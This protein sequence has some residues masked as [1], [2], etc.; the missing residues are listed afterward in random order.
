M[1][2]TYGLVERAIRHCQIL[3]TVLVETMISIVTEKLDTQKLLESVSSPKSGASVLFVGTTR[4]FTG[5]RETTFLS[6][7]CYREMAIVKLQELCDRAQEKWPIEKCG[8]V[9]RI[10]EVAIEEASVA[11]AVSSPHREEAFQAAEWLMERLK[12][13]VPIWKKEHGVDGGQHWV[14]EGS[15]IEPQGGSA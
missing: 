3:E 6:Y 9:H 1:T 10:G 2:G 14:H 12:Q 11:V 8:I 15:V 13:E 4:Q 7:E 5:Q